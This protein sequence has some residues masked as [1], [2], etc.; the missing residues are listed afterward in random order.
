MTAAIPQVP[1]PTAIFGFSPELNRHKN[2]PRIKDVTS[3]II[4]DYTKGTFDFVDKTTFQK[5]EEFRAKIDNET[6]ERHIKDVERT[7]LTRQ[8]PL[9]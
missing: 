6:F 5:L 2:D 3:K 4:L 7:T 1:V 8:P 9:G